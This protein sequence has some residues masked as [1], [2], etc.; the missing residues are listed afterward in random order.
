MPGFTYDPDQG[1]LKTALTRQNTVI[2]SV[3]EH[4]EFWFFLV[5]HM[6]IKFLYCT[7]HLEG[8]NTDGDAL[9]LGWS[10]ISVITAITTF[11]AVFYSNQ[12][13][14][15]YLAL[16]RKTKFSLGC[17]YDFGFLVRLTFQRTNVQHM[18]LAYRFFA[19]SIYL[20]LQH[21]KHVHL[22]TVPE[23]TMQYLIRNRY[24]TTP[25]YRYL[26]DLPI[27][28]RY[29][30][31]QQWATEVVCNAYAE[32]GQ[33]PKPPPHEYVNLKEKPEF[34]PLP[35]R[36]ATMFFQAVMTARTQRD[37]MLEMLALPVP[38]QYFHV[39]SVMIL[40]NVA[41]WCYKMATNA[42]ILTP[43]VFMVTQAIFMGM[44]ELAV[45]LANPFGDDDVDFPLD[46]WIQDSF[47]R[48]ADFMENCS[49]GYEDEWEESLTKQGALRWQSTASGDP[50]ASP[51]PPIE[52]DGTTLSTTPFLGYL[53]LTFRDIA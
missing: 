50:P 32:R 11:F 22:A 19:A 46:D 10:N 43:F 25:E 12:S 29:L 30:R 17:V 51:G 42:S 41:F 53:P 49:P 21:A 48:C 7:G 52:S 38:F 34:R 16:Y 47:R 9:H 23:E 39:L 5:L 37:E 13:Y 15:R 26:R 4:Y 14:T 8:A 20:S 40:V 31:L 35:V 33:A 28:D 1:L 36:K 18:R 44:L 24:L 2:P 27:E 6:I 3:L 45:Q